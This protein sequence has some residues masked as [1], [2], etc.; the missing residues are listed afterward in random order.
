MTPALQHELR[1]FILDALVDDVFEPFSAVIADFDDEE[2]ML[3]GIIPYPIS[4]EEIVAAMEELV[5]ERM[6]TLH[7]LSDDPSKG[8]YV[9]ADIADLQ[10]SERLSD[11][12]FHLTEKGRAA[13]DKWTP[14]ADK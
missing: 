14:L 2:C 4:Q 10:E 6:I 3:W 12:W 9:N 7:K 11:L 8:P 13:W 1:M 5:R